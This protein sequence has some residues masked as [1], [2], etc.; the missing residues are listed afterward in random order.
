MEKLFRQLT[1]EQAEF[2]LLLAERMLE[3]IQ[4]KLK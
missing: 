3:P 2:L 4:E 1:P